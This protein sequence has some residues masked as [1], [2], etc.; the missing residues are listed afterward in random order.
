M[1]RIVS[2]DMLLSVVPLS[3]GN[4]CATTTCSAFVS[5]FAQFC[6]SS[7]MYCVSCLV[8][9]ELCSRYYAN[10]LVDHLKNFFDWLEECCNA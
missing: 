2:F 8:T 10:D 7:S 1:H 9:S 5:A 6:M 3:E 4:A